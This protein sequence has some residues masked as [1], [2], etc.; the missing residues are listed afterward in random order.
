MLSLLTIASFLS[1]TSAIICPEN[2]CDLVTVLK[3]ECKGSVLRHGGFCDCNQ[4]CARIEGETCGILVFMGV[5]ETGICDTGLVC[6]L[7]VVDGVE[8]HRCTKVVEAQTT[9]Q[10]VEETCGTPCRRKSV[11]CAI[12]MIVFEGQWFA[13]CD[14]EGNFLPEQCDNTDHCFCVNTTT[15]AVLE[16]T[17]VI[18]NANC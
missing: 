11:H 12:S 14:A 18:G 16:G 5:N 17:K 2:Y 8:E 10:P 13:N 15:G 6:S 1:L 3:I 4:I 7:V 9:R